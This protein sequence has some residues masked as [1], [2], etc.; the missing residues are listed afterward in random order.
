[1]GNQVVSA[2]VR[3]LSFG[4]TSGSQDPWVGIAARVANE[5]NYVYL[6][7]R[8]SGQL[9]LRK[10]VNGSIQQIAAVPQT[11]TPGTWYDLR[12]EIIGNSIRAHV[13][14]DLRIEAN[15]ATIPGSGRNAVLMYRTAADLTDYIAYLP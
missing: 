14:G 11:L 4:P 15:D 2:R 3:P 13:N 9:S 6:T 8:R 12:L 10:L 5:N 7:L 1:M